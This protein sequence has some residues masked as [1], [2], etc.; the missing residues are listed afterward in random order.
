MITNATIYPM[1]GPRGGHNPA[2]RPAHVLTDRARRNL[3]RMNAAART[4]RTLG[5]RVLECRLDGEWPAVAEP[6]IRIERDIHR[7]FAAFLNAAGPREWVTVAHDGISTKS[8]ACRLEG[9]WIIWE[10]PQ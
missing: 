6:S 9:V 1:H 3:A 4:L 2:Q 5:V 8:A 7:S 10:E